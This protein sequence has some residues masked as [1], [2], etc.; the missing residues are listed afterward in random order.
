MFTYNPFCTG[1]PERLQKGVWYTGEE[2]QVRKRKAWVLEAAQLIT[3][4][5][6]M[7]SHLFPVFLICLR[8]GLDSK[9]PLS[10]LIPNPSLIIFR[11]SQENGWPITKRHSIVV[12]CV[13][14]RA[15]RIMERVCLPWF[16]RNSNS[17]STTQDV[18]RETEHFM[19]QG[20]KY[21]SRSGEGVWYKWR[22]DGLWV[23]RVIK[24]LG[25]VYQVVRGRIGLKPRSP[26]G[27]AFFPK[28]VTSDSFFSL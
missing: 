7:S 13:I 2:S 14:A 4:H 6:I 17:F 23:N 11:M 9:V 15:I 16:V 1:W 22:N 25:Q 21:F 12:I 20:F 28:Y 5:V 3:C 26:G 27:L 8:T 19:L 18:Q 24:G 10:S